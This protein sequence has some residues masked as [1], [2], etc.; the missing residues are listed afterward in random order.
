MDRETDKIVVK[1]ITNNNL[2]DMDIL[3]LLKKIFKFCH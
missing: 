1:K 3:T 2:S